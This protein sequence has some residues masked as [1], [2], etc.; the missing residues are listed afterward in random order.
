[1]LVWDPVAQR[2]DADATPSTGTETLGDHYRRLARGDAED[3]RGAH[4]VF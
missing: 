1:M 2:Y 3:D 4:A